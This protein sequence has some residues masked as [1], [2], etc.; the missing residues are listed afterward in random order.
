M[1]KAKRQAKN[2]VVV[3]DA[4]VPVVGPR[5][6]C[7]C[8][9]GRRYKACHGQAAARAAT[10]RV[11]RPFEGLPGECDLVALSVLVPAATTSLELNDGSTLGVASLLPLAW[12]AL[13]RVDDQVFVGLQVVG[14][15]GDQSRDIAAA[16]L[17]A[18]ELPP[19]SPVLETGRPGEGQ[20]LQDLVKPD[21]KPVV[22]VYEG[23]DYWLDSVAAEITDDVK[24]SLERANENVVPTAKLEAVDAAYWCRIGTKEHL[25]WV[26]PHDEDELLNALARLAADS[27]LDLGAGTKY[28]GCFRSHGL[29]AAVWDLAPGDEAAD[30]E[31]PAAAFRKRLDEALADTSELSAEAR[32]LRTGLLGRQ[33]TLI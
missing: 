20:R 11:L 5:E 25:R 15:S 24:A 30:I 19:G 9:S 2:P 7:P 21:Q 27:K 29:L 33:V 23:F 14:G 10:R 17:A 18:K 22:T 28:V 6:P 3:D 4:D 1:A 32:R 26:L 8:G 31:E 12:P 16:Y 13:H